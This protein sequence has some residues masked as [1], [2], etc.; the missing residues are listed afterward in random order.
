MMCGLALGYLLINIFGMTILY[1]LNSTLEKLIEKS[2]G[3][4]ES[5]RSRYEVYL[6]K[7]R[8]MILIFYLPI[9]ILVAISHTFFSGI[10]TDRNVLTYAK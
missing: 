10:T 6:N 8:I 4:Y 1:G 7:G 3:D 5:N 2:G 9:V